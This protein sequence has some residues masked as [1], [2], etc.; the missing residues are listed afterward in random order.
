M[1]E[2]RDSSY[3]RTMRRPVFAVDFQWICR[4]ESP[5]AY[6]RIA[7]NDMS[8]STRRRVGLPSRS[9][10]R[11]AL[12][13][14]RAIVRG[15][16]YS[17]CTSSKACSR[18]SSPIGSL[19]TVVAVR[20]R[21]S[22][23]ARA[24]MSSGCAIVCP[25]RSSGTPNS[26][27]PRPTGRSMRP[28]SATPTAVVAHD[29]LA[30][31]AVAGDDPLM[32][33]RE[34]HV[35][36]RARRTGTGTLAISSSSGRRSGDHPLHPAERDAQREP[37]SSRR[38]TTSAPA[39]RT[40]RR[41]PRR[42][43]GRHASPA[44]RHAPAHHTTARTSARPRRAEVTAVAVDLREPV[45]AGGG[46]GAGEA[47]VGAHTASRSTGR[48]DVEQH[49]ADDGLWR[50]AVELGLGVQDEAVREHGDRRATSRRRASRRCGPARRRAC[51]R[52]A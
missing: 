31:D 51:V 21:R 40:V 9:R 8:E 30:V 17:W 47:G 33:E 49:L 46:G 14:G 20:R 45:R 1:R 44:A 35:V 4:R 23:A 37:R 5:A 26:T 3:W 43:G 15:W 39:G 38:R 42:R 19:R 28:G 25:G 34:V 10:M 18:R 52:R 41:A 12:V 2:R 36:R 48:R 11:P 16:T 22:R 32:R 50:H 29:D 6:S 7:W 13:D 24:G 27:R